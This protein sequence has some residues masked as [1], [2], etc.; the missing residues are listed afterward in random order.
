MNNKTFEIEVKDD[1]LVIPPEIQDYLS[2]CQGNTKVSITITSSS[3]NSDD[4]KEK[5]ERWFDE[6]E[7]I[8]LSPSV[9]QTF[10]EKFDKLS[11]E[12]QKDVLEFL[13]IIGGDVSETPK[14]LERK[15]AK[16][17]LQRAKERA[18]SNVSKL[19]DELW[20]DFNQVKDQIASEFEN[21]QS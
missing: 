5:W 4:L 18:K 8:E 2:Q 14:N 16:E 11:T 17:I 7:N 21:K 13:D 9:Q 6:V 10:L 1:I 3:D 20:S 15:Q 12:Q 19:V